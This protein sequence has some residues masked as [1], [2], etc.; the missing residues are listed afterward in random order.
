M[1][2]FFFKTNLV[3]SDISQCIWSPSSR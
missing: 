1:N 2:N 3:C